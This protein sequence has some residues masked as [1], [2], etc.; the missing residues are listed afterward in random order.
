MES[1]DI[2]KLSLELSLLEKTEDFR[3]NIRRVQFT[4]KSMGDYVLADLTRKMLLTIEE[5]IDEMNR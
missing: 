1:R 4:A 3:A 5:Y 2:N